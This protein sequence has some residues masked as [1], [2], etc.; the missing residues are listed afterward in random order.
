MGGGCVGDGWGGRASKGADTTR[1]ATLRRPTP[2]H[3]T[4][5]LLAVPSPVHAA[6]HPTDATRTH[7][8][9]SA[10]ALVASE[11]E[12]RELETQN[13][14][15]RGWGQAL[16]SAN[17]REAQRSVVHQQEAQRPVQRYWSPGK[18]G[19]GG[20]GGEGGAAG[21]AGVGPGR[22][23]AEVGRVGGAGTLSL[24][25]ASSSPSPTAAHTPPPRQGPPTDL[26]AAFYDE[27]EANEGIFGS[28]GGASLT[29]KLSPSMSTSMSG[30]DGDGERESRPGRMQA[31]GTTRTTNLG[32][33]HYRGY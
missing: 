22:G 29:P 4:P 30:D 21:G 1:H 24:A 33:A 32:D 13:H 20:R 3:A 27:G 17:R 19:Q 18:E 14:E 2:R 31:H 12:N 23:G 5:R 8:R 9:T 7:A 6:D 16:R 10:A 28:G 25:V 15:L 26:S 11:R